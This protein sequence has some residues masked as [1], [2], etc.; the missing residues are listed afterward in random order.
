MQIF[1]ASC[2]QLNLQ[3]FS[4]SPS[5]PKKNATRANATLSVIVWRENMALHIC[6]CAVACLPL[7]I[8]LKSTLS[9][10]QTTSLLVRLAEATLF[11]GDL[12]HCDF[13][14][15]SFSSSALVSVFRAFH[16]LQFTNLDEAKHKA[17]SKIEVEANER[18]GEA[19]GKAIKDIE[20]QTN[21]K[22]CRETSKP[23][24]ISPQL[25]KAKSAFPQ[26]PKT[27][28]FVNWRIRVRTKSA[29][30]APTH[31]QHGHPPPTEFSCVSTV[32]LLIDPWG[33]T[34]HLSAV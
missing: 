10:Q 27:L 8:L 23:T 18:E 33:C 32:Q 12:C 13:S 14:L 34:W 19:S 30:T 24:E 11:F 21:I 26:P 4:P 5:S 3:M 20:K 29:L 16:Q 1:F 31:V 9:L 6:C 17:I 28:N 7:S 25:A 15:F 22:Q 2:F